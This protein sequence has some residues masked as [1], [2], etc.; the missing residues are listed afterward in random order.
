M[1]S[2]ELLETKSRV[3]KSLSLSKNKYYPKKSLD[4]IIFHLQEKSHKS[5][6]KQM[7]SLANRKYQ[8]RIKEYLETIEQEGKF[9]EVFQIK[10]LKEYLERM[11]NYICLI[12]MDLAISLN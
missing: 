1:I 9:D 11:F 6:H 3:E 12:I 7:D 10:L 5:R 2:R 4:N 8:N